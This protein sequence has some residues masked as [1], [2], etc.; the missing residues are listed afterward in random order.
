M[1]L[2]FLCDSWTDSEDGSKTI[3]SNE[4]LK[5]HSSTGEL[6]VWALR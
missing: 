1:W 6:Y 5:K 2:V 3:V 4:V